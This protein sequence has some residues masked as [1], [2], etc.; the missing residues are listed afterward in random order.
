MTLPQ[1]F[2][3][4]IGWSVQRS[5]VSKTEASL[6][7]NNIDTMFVKQVLASMASLPE[8]K[9]LA[10]VEQQLEEDVEK[11]EEKVKGPTTIPQQMLAFAAVVEE[12]LD[13]FEASCFG[14]RRLRMRE[15]KSFEFIKKNPT[16]SWHDACEDAINQR[17]SYRLHVQNPFGLECCATQSES[18]KRARLKMYPLLN[19]GEPV[20]R[21]TKERC[22]LMRQAPLTCGISDIR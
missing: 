9:K 17:L 1:C 20:S 10:E 21:R 2:K 5:C 12:A 4:Q 22:R 13:D 7:A 3:W 19:A 18:A 15:R 11:L 8:D 16:V 6:V 14:E